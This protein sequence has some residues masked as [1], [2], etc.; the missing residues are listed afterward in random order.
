MKKALF[1][2]TFDPFTIGHKDIVDRALGLCDELTICIG[3][4]E[5]K[6]CEQSPEERKTNIECVYADEP[7]VKVVIWSGLTVDYCTQNDIHYIVKGVR[8]VRDFEYERDQADM[9]R[10]LANVDTILLYCDPKYSA[11]SSS[12]IKVLKANGRDVSDYLA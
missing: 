12:L 7:R 9:N 10:H 4:N 3:Y 1:P 8:N 6:H 5:A 11:I 2:G